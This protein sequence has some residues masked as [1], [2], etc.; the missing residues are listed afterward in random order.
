MIHLDMIPQEGDLYQTVCVYG[1][2]FSL[3]YGYYEDSDR[4]NGEPVV[5]YPDLKAEPCYAPDG[6]PLVTAV[7]VPC[8]WYVPIEPDAPEGCCSDCISYEDRRREITRCRH[9]QQ[10]CEVQSKATENMLHDEK[11]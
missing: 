11:T 6:S 3:R 5:L 4:E 8:R 9:P 2:C 7:Q 10:R 1:H